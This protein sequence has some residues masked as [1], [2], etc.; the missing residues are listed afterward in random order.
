MTPHEYETTLPRL[1]TAADERPD[2]AFA[3]TSLPSADR[4]PSA[5]LTPPPHD[6]VWPGS[7]ELGGSRAVEV[8][9][10]DRLD[11]GQAGGRTVSD[12]FGDFGEGGEVE[13]ELVEARGEPAESDTG[14][15]IAAKTMGRPLRPGDEIASYR[16]SAG[17]RLLI[18]AGGS[19]GLEIHDV[20]ADFLGDSYRVDHAPEDAECLWALVA[21]YLAQAE[22]HD[23]PPMSGEALAAVMQV[24]TA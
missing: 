15:N 21:D 7:G 5:H 3:A 24:G 10:K 19:R 17:E 4:Q 23:A 16:V 9:A 20:A 13:I 1:A 14:A 22:R 2:R 12:D 18:C 8:A 6:C 11:G